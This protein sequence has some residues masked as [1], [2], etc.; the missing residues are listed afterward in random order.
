[1]YTMRKL[2]ITWFL[3]ALFLALAFAPQGYAQ[4]SESRPSDVCEGATSRVQANPLL[5]L[6]VVARAEDRAAALRTKLFDVQTQEFDLQSRIE[7]LDYQLTPE[8]IQRAS[9]TPEN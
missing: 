7:E 5:D 2:Q 8:S 1:M 3:A 6:E 4:S 9:F